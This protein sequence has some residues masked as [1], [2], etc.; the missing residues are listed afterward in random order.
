KALTPAFKT[1]GGWVS[2]A[3]GYLK[4]FAA[5]LGNIKMPDW[6]G[7]IGA[8]ALSWAKKLIPGGGNS[9]PDG[10]HYHGLDKA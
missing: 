9:K 8:G 7:K 3:A 10:S 1:V 5:I 4:D 2:T 6:I